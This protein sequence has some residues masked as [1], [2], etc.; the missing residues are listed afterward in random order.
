MIFLFF[1]CVISSDTHE[2]ISIIIVGD[3]TH[4]Y[5]KLIIQFILFEIHIH[6]L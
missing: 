6:Y 4:T 5:K 2:I 3:T 1:M